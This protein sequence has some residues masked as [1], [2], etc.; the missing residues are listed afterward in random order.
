MKQ[1]LK[2]VN[3]KFLFLKSFVFTYFWLCWVFS[4]LC[5]LSL[6]AESRGYSSL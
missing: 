5:G 1:V 4:A 6:V 3:F 2:A